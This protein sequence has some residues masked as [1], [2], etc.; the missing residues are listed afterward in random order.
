MCASCTAYS[1]WF[2]MEHGEEMHTDNKHCSFLYR[3]YIQRQRGHIK[4]GK[5]AFII[6]SLLVTMRSIKVQTCM[7][8]FIF[9]VNKEAQKDR[10]F[11][12]I[13]TD[14][15]F[16]SFPPDLCFW[17]AKQ[18]EDARLQDRQTVRCVRGEACT[19]EEKWR[20]AMHTLWII[21]P[22]LCTIS[23][24]TEQHTW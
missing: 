3:I 1:A 8:Q 18:A 14:A 5:W 13:L 10:T 23:G 16:L 4:A 24:I 20:K 6:T 21:F 22:H 12:L 9:A 15:C 2:E 11:F 7:T 19:G 17:H